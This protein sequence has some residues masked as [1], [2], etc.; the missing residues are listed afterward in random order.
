[1][2][3]K[4]MIL[5]GLFAL[6][7]IFTSCDDDGNGPAGP[8]NP[9]ESFGAFWVRLF[10]AVTDS[11]SENPAHTRIEGKI[12]DG[13]SPPNIVFEEVMTIGDC[14][15]LKALYPSCDDCGSSATCVAKDSC[16][17][18]PSSYSVGNVTVNGLKNN[19]SKITFTIEPFIMPFSTDYQMIN[20]ALDYPPFSEGDTVT[21]AAAGSEF[22]SPFTLTA[23]GIAPLNVS[24]DSVVLEDNKPITLKWDPPSM[25]GVSTISVRI[26]VSYHGGTK[27]E[28]QCDCADDGELTVPAELLDK[29]MAWG[30]AG[31]P[32]ADITRKSVGVDETAK[33]ELVVES[34]VTKG[35]FIPGV[36]SCNDS[37]ECPEGQKCIERRCQ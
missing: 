31:W 27:G 28:I 12:N 29:L 22:A 2:S 25:A 6:M 23:R 5:G 1:M 17:P 19:G 8:E 37:T 15:L 4:K 9:V 33:T 18:K 16:Q 7:M 14:K 30:F 11:A 21:L 32:V 34:M 13:P 24:K 3:C 26:N 10:A 35:L 20:V 36:I